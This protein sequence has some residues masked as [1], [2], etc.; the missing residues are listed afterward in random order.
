VSGSKGI[1]A[2]GGSLGT[3][4]EYGMRMLSDGRFFV[5]TD[6]AVRLMSKTNT[7]IPASQ[8]SH[9]AATFNSSMI[10]LHY[11]LMEC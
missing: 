7:K 11:T 4:L 1:L 2:K 10:H 8:W 9:V 5:T 3:A 6:G